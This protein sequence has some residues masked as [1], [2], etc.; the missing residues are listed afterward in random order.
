MSEKNNEKSQITGLLRDNKVFI[1][2]MEGIDEFYQG[3]YIGTLEKGKEGEDNLI[4]NP[5]ETLLLIERKRLLI[6][7][8]NDPSNEKLDF[9]KL[10][11]YFTRFDDNLWHKYIIYNDLRRR[12][13]IV[14]DGYGEGIEFLVYKRGADFQ[15]DTAK[16][17]IF[18]VFEGEP[19]ELKDL[20]KISRV[21]LSSRKD[22]IVATVDRTSKATYYSVKKFEI[23]KIMESVELEDAR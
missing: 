9:E 15:K 14:R 3:S 10:M 7:E 16:Y 17:L 6:Y 21:A 19:I 1:E 12:G 13:Y 4:L 5:M 8:N 22:L 20:D 2:D 18:P 11:E 23:S